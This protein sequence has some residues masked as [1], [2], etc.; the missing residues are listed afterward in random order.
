[1][2]GDKTSIMVKGPSYLVPSFGEA[3]ERQRFLA[4]SQ[5]LSPFVKGLKVLV[6]RAFMI[7]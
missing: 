7:C 5:T 3:R 2:I 1:V 6:E 4:L